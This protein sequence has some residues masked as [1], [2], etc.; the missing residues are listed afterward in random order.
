MISS[1]VEYRRNDQ[2]K[3]QKAKPK[4]WMRELVVEAGRMGV[5]KGSRSLSSH[6]LHVVTA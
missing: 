5:Y 2:R 6:F 4:G 3:R 1:Q